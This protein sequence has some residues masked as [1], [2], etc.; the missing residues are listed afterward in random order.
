[1]CTVNEHDLTVFNEKITAGCTYEAAAAAGHVVKKGLIKIT[2]FCDG[3]A[4]MSAL[5]CDTCDGG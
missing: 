1:M 4:P 5:D 2:V 3:Y